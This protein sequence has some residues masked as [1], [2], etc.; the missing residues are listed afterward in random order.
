MWATTA[1][2]MNGT[3]DSELAPLGCAPPG[4]PLGRLG[5]PDD[6]LDHE[7]QG[8]ESP[9]QMELNPIDQS[10]IRIGT[11]VHNTEIAPKANICSNF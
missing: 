4:E 10:T 5:R 11:V 7:E 3:R 6:E 2:C 9:T 1:R 8:D